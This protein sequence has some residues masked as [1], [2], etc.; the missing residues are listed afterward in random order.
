MFAFAWISAPRESL[1]RDLPVFIMLSAVFGIICVGGM[2]VFTLLGPFV[3]GPAESM[4]SLRSLLP[5]SMQIACYLAPYLTLWCVFGGA[6]GLVVYFADEAYVFRGLQDL[7]GVYHETLVV[8]AW[9]VPNS[10]WGIWFFVLV[11]R[12]AMAAAYANR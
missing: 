4:R 6:T 9:L 2:V 10:A 7:T 3:T 12:G 5:A 8:L 1:L 11:H